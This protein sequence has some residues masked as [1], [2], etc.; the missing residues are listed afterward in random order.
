MVDWNSRLALFHARIY[1]STK[2]KSATSSP[3]SQTR[4]GASTTS[5]RKQETA[6]KLW[7][8]LARSYNAVS[9]RL[10]E[11]I[12]RHELTPTEFAILEVLYHKGPLLLGEVQ[13]KI[14]VTSGGITYLVDRLVEKG[15]VKREEC[16]ED[17]RARYA[18]LTPAG[19]A[20]IRRIFPQHVVALE[21]TLSGLSSAEQREAV[22]L[23]RKLG[24]AAAAQGEEE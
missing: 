13:R 15:F 11:D 18:V 22:S 2:M 10:S 20:L 5:D 1:L 17:R 9:A 23:L 7:V 12:A 4:S 21:Q 16:P 6:L 8:V 24:L 14:L 19:T 3:R